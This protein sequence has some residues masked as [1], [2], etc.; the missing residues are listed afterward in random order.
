MEQ[1]R[2]FE[3]R[4]LVIQIASQHGGGSDQ[5]VSDHYYW[6]SGLDPAF[7]GLLPLTDSTRLVTI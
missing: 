3:R 6:P 7:G 4:V 2:S 1:G 5:L